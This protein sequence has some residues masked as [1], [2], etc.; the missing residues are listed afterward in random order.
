MVDSTSVSSRAWLQHAHCIS[1]VFLSPHCMILSVALCAISSITLLLGT[2]IKQEF[3]PRIPYAI[4]AVQ[5]DD[6]SDDDEN[7]HK[8]FRQLTTR[9]PHAVRS[10]TKWFI[11]VSHLVAAGT[12]QCNLH[13]ALHEVTSLPARELGIARLSKHWTAAPNQL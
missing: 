1:F 12:W 2:T 6:D 13:D 5:D 3:C 7:G 11:L 4:P 8:N 10:E 9:M